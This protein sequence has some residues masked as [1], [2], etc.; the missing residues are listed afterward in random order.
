MDER[1]IYDILN[2]IFSHVA[3]DTGFKDDILDDFK[4]ADGFAKINGKH[5]NH[6]SVSKSGKIYK[7]CII[8]IPL[9]STTNT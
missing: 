9:Q 6:P 1:E 8:F 7:R 3:M 4:T 5:S 2:H